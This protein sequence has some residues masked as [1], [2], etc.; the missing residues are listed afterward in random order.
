MP[1]YIKLVVVSLFYKLAESCG[2][3]LLLLSFQEKWKCRFGSKFWLDLYK[4]VLTSKIHGCSLRARLEDFILYLKK[5][6]NE[7]NNQK[8]LRYLV[9]CVLCRRAKW[10]E[11]SWG[12]VRGG[13]KTIP[14]SFLNSSSSCFFSLS[15]KCSSS[16]II[17]HWS[18]KRWGFKLLVDCFFFQASSKASSLALSLFNGLCKFSSLGKLIPCFPLWC[19]N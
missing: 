2:S 15:P 9:E 6:K 5:M 1:S 17:L 8:G 4:D 7:A 12:I 11:K 14:L 18:F 19:K 3:P 10:E 16:S 13:V